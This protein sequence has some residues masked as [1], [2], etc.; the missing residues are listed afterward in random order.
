MHQRKSELFQ[1]TTTQEK[2]Q[3]FYNTFQVKYFDHLQLEEKQKSVRALAHRQVFSTNMFTTGLSNF[4]AGFCWR[5]RTPKQ[6]IGSIVYPSGN[7]EQ[8]NIEDFSNIDIK[9]LAR[10]EQGRPVSALSGKS[11]PKWSRLYHAY[12]KHSRS[13][14]HS[15][16]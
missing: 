7:V 11:V 5:L 8:H 6:R 2:L 3:S 15:R 12:S 9:G 1:K 13:N 14:L 16:Y 4:T 10:S